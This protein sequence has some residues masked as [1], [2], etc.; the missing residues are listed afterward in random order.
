MPSSRSG[1]AQRS[2]VE[3][4]LLRSPLPSLAYSP[5]GKQLAVA[6]HVDVL[7]L[8]TTTYTE[9][10]RLQGHLAQ[11]NHVAYS[12]DGKRIATAGEDQTVRLWD[13]RSGQEML[14]LKG[15]TNLV[16]CVTF[17]PDG[18][19]LFSGGWDRTIRTWDATPLD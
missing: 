16:R 5:D 12:P 19:R 8:D 7:L 4:A 18:H 9:V 14:T 15:H 3:V 2:E 13:S 11:V 10:R 17:S 1:S 6:H